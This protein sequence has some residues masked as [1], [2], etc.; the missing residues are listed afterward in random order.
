[1]GQIVLY[2]GNGGSQDI[3]QTFQ[4]KPGQN[5]RVS[6]NDEAKSARLLAV[7][8]GTVITVYDSPD[9]KLD[10]D[11]CVIRV[12]EYSDDYTVG[13]FERS[14]SDKYVSV[15]YARR[16]G[17]DGKVSRIRIDD[18]G[19]SGYLLGGIT[20]ERSGDEDKGDSYQDRGA[21]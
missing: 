19:R 21:S 16:N 18:D 20:F 13:T 9:G 15:S 3:V 17:L 6:P 12:R 7:R 11:F 4:D 5:R 8:P 10:D 2:E 1:M 14:Y